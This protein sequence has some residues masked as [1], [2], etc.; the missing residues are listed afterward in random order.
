[1]LDIES[2]VPIWN[3]G[4]SG[5]IFWSAETTGWSEKV[6]HQHEVFGSERGFW[7]RQVYTTVSEPFTPSFM[8]K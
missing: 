1:M 6:R 2:V 7:R 5:Q 3:A 4:K 8:W